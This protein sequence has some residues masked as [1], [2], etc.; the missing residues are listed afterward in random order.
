MNYGET[1]VGGRP[2]DP[3]ISIGLDQAGWSSFLRGDP[4]YAAWL[5]G[6]PGRES[7]L[8][9]RRAAAIR[10]ALLHF[11]RLPGNFKDQYGD[12]TPADMAA[13][14]GN[15]FS[16]EA[17]IQRAY[18]QGIDN[19]HRSLAAR[20]MLQ[21]GEVV[22]GQHQADVANAQAEQSAAEAF[23]A[24]ITG[25]VGDYTS[26]M[27]DI[28]GEEAGVIGQAEQNVFS[29]NPNPTMQADLVAGS[30]D[31]YGYPVYRT[32]DGRTWRLDPDTGL[33][34]PWVSPHS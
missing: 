27:S 32:Q 15:K 26:G 4:G 7:S 28:A 29:Q 34:V 16:D 18:R 5:A 24:A 8:A 12:I 10:Q 21:S 31:Q 1:G 22:S 17:N 25:S 33:P 6:R 19:L 14:Q 11:G 3:N 13:A 23:M 30:S 9:S 2:D 20:G